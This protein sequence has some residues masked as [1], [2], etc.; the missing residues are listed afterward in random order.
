MVEF[1]YQNLA[2]SLIIQIDINIIIFKS[3]KLDLNESESP[4]G[5]VGIH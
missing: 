3:F 5:L 2:M 1:G 4:Q